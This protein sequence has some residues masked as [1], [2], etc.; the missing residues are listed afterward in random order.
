MNL[1]GKTNVGYTIVRQGKEAVLAHNENQNM[2]VA[3][4][5]NISD[6]K[7]N[8]FWGRYGSFES[9][10]IAFNKKEKGEYSG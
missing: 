2:Y 8:Y 3:W 7:P 6:N 10:T 5:Y 4:S 9:A 1:I